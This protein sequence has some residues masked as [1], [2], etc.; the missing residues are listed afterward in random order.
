MKPGT[1]HVPTYA[2]TF[3]KM[4]LSVMAV[5]V[6]GG[7]L[8]FLLAGVYGPLLFLIGFAVFYLS[9]Y[10]WQ[11]VDVWHSQTRWVDMGPSAATKPL[12]TALGEAGFGPAS[13][14]PR[15]YFSGREA[16]DLKGGLNVTIVDYQE[17]C[18]IYVGP[19]NVQTHRDVENAKWVIDKT[20][21]ALEAP[22][23]SRA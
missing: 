5:V 19:D 8:I 22:P 7:L 18:Q 15:G 20:L 14:K 4:V 17:S 16:Y 11:E 9:V 3:I 1:W 12:V 21:A 23:T 13:R 6:I 2:R 10:R